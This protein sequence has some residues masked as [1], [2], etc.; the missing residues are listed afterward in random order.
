MEVGPWRHKVARARQH[1]AELERELA[2]V[3]EDPPYRLSS[4]HE[5]NDIVV[6]VEMFGEIP[7]QLSLIVG[8][9]LHNARSALDVLVFELAQSGE[10]ELRRVPDDREARS[11]SFP[12]TSDV[13][14]FHRKAKGLARFLSADALSRLEEMQPWYLTDNP[15]G[16][17]P[18]YDPA[19]RA[20]A[21]TLDRLRRLSILDN[22]DKH[23]MVLLTLW[24]PNRIRHGEPGP[25]D[26]LGADEREDEAVLEVVDPETIAM[27]TAAIEAEDQRADAVDFYFAGGPIADGAEVGRFMRHDRGLVPDGQQVRGDLRLVIREPELTGKWIGGP[28]ASGLMAGFIDEVEFTCGYVSGTLGSSD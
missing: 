15:H 9:L 18:I 1:Q 3:H 10:G 12:I 28:E 13:S 24:L 23:R 19:D 2:R 11:L 7:V 4:R 8:D 21:I 20:D 5:G 27:L 26:E 25:F 17:E 22:V 14:S 16:G 6:R